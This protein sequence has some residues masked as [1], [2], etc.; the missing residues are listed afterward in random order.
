MN[1]DPT[2]MSRDTARAEVQRL[3]ATLH[4]VHDH[5]HQGRTDE[6]H[7]ALHCSIGGDEP[8]TGNL[9]LADAA[10]LQR[11]AGAF[12]KL[13]L[14][15]GV[16]AASVTLVRSATVPGAASLQIGGHVPTIQVLRQMLGMS[17]TNAV[18]A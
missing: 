8:N 4:V 11:F 10:T 13:C 12:N 16:M 2:T 1:Q 18:R 9:T 17:P 3:T 14:E 6:A 15:H 5:L 7:Q